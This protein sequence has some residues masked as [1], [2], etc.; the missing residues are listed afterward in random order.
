MKSNRK[1]A[2]EKGIALITVIAVLM[3]LALIATPFAVSMKDKHQSA[4]FFSAREKAR[5]S[6]EGA[7]QH[8]LST[9]VNTHPAH[10]QTPHS[11]SP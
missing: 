6:A 8:A 10:D 11:Y 3:L 4:L 7:V 5:L 1:I 2:S 9:L